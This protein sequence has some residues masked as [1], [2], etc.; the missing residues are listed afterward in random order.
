MSFIAVEPPVIVD[1][2]VTVGA[3][4]GEAL[5]ERSLL[6]WAATGRDMLAPIQVWMETANALVRGW[7][8]SAVDTSGLLAA[9][10]RMGIAIADR[11]PDGIDGAVVLA[12]RHGLTVYDAAYLWLAID[13]DGELATFDQALIR[14]AQAEG[15]ELAIRP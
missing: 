9:L 4:T 6:Q 14:A 15:V 3:A 8:L 10:G 1:A 11:G 2:S 13:V 12:D 7:R 5:A